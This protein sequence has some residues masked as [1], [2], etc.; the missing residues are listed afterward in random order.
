MFNTNKPV[1]DYTISTTTLFPFNFK[2]FVTTDIEVRV[3]GIK[4]PTTDYTV[5]I[6]GDLGGTVQLLKTYGTADV[7]NLR[8]MLPIIRTVDYQQYGDLRE[9]TLDDDQDYQTYLILDTQYYLSGGGDPDATMKCCNFHDLGTSIGKSIPYTASETGKEDI[10]VKS[11]TN[12]FSMD[13]II[14]T[15]GASL[16]VENNATYKVI[17]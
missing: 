3:K 10:V 11:G 17:G 13:Q 14:I 7:L 4:I 6:N 2:I 5:I 15:T 9:K 8:R 12:G 1:Q 16:T